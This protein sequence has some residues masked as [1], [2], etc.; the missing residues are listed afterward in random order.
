MVEEPGEDR[1]K[2]LG[3]PLFVV[4][5]R[6]RY[7]SAPPPQDPGL[8][9]WRDQGRCK[10]DNQGEAGEQQEYTAK[11][12][13]DQKGGFPQGVCGRDV[14]VFAFE[15]GDEPSRVGRVHRTS[16]T[17]VPYASTSMPAVPLPSRRPVASL[18]VSRRTPMMVSQPSLRASSFIRN[19]ASRRPLS[20]SVS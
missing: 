11:H 15:L 5:H 8:E 7:S 16:L 1:F 6:G 12:T 14:D 2:G 13:S 9:R 10:I 3:T 19:S 4:V 18:E 17:A 20:S